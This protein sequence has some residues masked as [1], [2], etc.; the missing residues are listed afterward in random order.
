MS[1]KITKSMVAVSIIT[2]VLSMFMIIGVLYEYFSG[3]QI[4]QQKIE[5]ELAAKGVDLSGENYLSSLE[6]NQYRITLIRQD[7]LVVFDSE[8]DTSEMQNHSNREEFIEAINNGYGES[9]RY[10]FTLGENTYYSAKRLSDGNVIRISTVRLSLLSIVLSML[11]P[12]IEI[13]FIA[14]IICIF[15]SRS[16]SKKIVKP[17]NNIDFDYPFK[18]PAYDEL[19]PLLRRID[20]QN[21]KI[22][23]QIKKLE[24][25]NKEISVVNENTSDGIVVISDIGNIVSANAKAKAILNCN[26]DEY[27]LDSYRNLSYQK[28]VEK[29]LKGINTSVVISIENKVYRFNASSIRT[30]NAK[31]NVFLFITDIT[32]EEKF[33][34]I[35]KQFSAN[36]SHELK[37]PLASIMGMSEIMANGIVKPEDIPEFARKINAESERLLKLIKDIIKLSQMD[38]GTINEQKQ[39]VCLNDVCKDIILQLSEKAKKLSVSVNFS[40]DNCSIYGIPSVINEIIYNLCDNAISYNKTGGFVNVSLCKSDNSVILKVADNG[41]GIAKEDI[42]RVFERFYRADK[43][44]SKETGGT[45]LG[46]S[47]VKHGAILHNALVSINSELD[48]GT[49]ITIQFPQ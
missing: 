20:K 35:R 33:Q 10:S 5:L 8:A 7:G 32:E 42:D 1:F 18:N 37:T 39:D 14:V 19:S 36:V 27:Y 38:E 12:M 34:E 15:I 48:K 44:H 25:I 11:Q 46:L 6:L 21:F 41:I 2:L 22:N 26:A 13:L 3:Q 9:K 45:G 30:D 29:A 24:H 4:S 28:A 31:N 43:S 16:L 40:G 17:I 47:I 23:N 49:E